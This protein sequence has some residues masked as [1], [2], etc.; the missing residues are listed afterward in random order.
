MPRA[1]PLLRRGPIQPYMTNTD[2]GELCVKVRPGPS[3]AFYGGY[4][5]YFD[6]LPFGATAP[7]LGVTLGHDW[8]NIS[9]SLVLEAL[10]GSMLRM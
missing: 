7:A 6:C 9:D 8:I 10:D 3:T 2:E 1:Y 4:G 5:N